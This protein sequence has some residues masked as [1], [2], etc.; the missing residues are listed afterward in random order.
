MLLSFVGTQMNTDTIESFLREGLIMKD[1]N[2]VHV[3]SLLGVSVDPMGIPLIVLPFMA[4]G[5]LKKYLMNP[6]V[7]VSVRMRVYVCVALLS[8]HSRDVIL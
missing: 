1:F 4:N 5:N 8:C 2:H 6:S 3:L 7:V